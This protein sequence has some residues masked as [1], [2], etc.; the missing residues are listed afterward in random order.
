[1]KRIFD[2]LLV[3]V[4]F[5]TIIYLALYFLYF[6]SLCESFIGKNEINQQQAITKLASCKDSLVCSPK[7]ILIDNRWE[8]SSWECEKNKSLLIKFF[9]NIINSII[10]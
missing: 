9:D 1:M 6:N 2:V 10:K 5:F 3:T 7:N 8:L 4:S